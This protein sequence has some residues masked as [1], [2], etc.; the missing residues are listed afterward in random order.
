MPK[1]PKPIVD[2]TPERLVEHIHAA[3]NG[4]LALA[5]SSTSGKWMIVC[6]VCKA[7][8]SLASPFPI[9]MSELPKDFKSVAD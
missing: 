2:E 9:V 1:K 5:V 6:V 7:T 3:D 4:R 8:W